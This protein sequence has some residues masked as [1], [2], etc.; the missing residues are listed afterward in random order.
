MLELAF[1]IAIVNVGIEIT[2]LFFLR[3]RWRL[4]FIGSHYGMNILWVAMLIGNLFIHGRNI[5]GP[6]A[7][8]AGALAIYWVG[9][10][11]ILSQLG[12]LWYVDD[13]LHYTQGRFRYWA[14]ELMNADEYESYINRIG[15]VQRTA[16]EEA[17]FKHYL[18][19]QKPIQQSFH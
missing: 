16:Y 11:L 3:P 1:L 4:L 17:E 8:F 14:N 15:S 12:K 9:H 5:L 10:K 7:S 18:D 2:L 6:T 19:M 13:Q